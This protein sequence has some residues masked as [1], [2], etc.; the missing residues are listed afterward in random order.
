MSLS[1]SAL[2]VVLIMINFSCSKNEADPQEAEARKL[3]SLEI[4]KA[5]N[6]PVI[7]HLPTIDSE[8]NS[9][10]RTTEEVAI[11]AMALCI[12]A[13]KGEGLEQEIID[14]L[15]NDFEL[16]D[17]FT[18]REKKFLTAP[19]PDTHTKTQ[20]VWRYEDYW[21]LLWALGYVDELKRPDSI[22]DV[23]TAIS[24]L[25]DKG[26]K[27][28]IKNAKLRPQGELLDATDLIYR[29]HWAVVDARINQ[30]PAPANLDGGV[31]MERHYVLNW[32]TGQGGQTWDDI[33]TDT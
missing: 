14:R 10:R 22:C 21:V 26:R 5:E 13:V 31:V 3:R 1:Q 16:M 23:E 25:R 18:P 4:L 27:Q 6:V 9:T 24:I 29:Y 32:L 2:L 8:A 17:A 28:F 33:S 12:V 7:A 20:F 15:I 30:R 19:N 11:R